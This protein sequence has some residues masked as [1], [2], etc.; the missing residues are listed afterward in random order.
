MAAIYGQLVAILP[1]YI[2]RTFEYVNDNPMFIVYSFCYNPQP[3]IIVIQLTCFLNS[4]NKYSFTNLTIKDLA[5]NIFYMEPKFRL[6]GLYYSLKFIH[7]GS[8]ILYLY[9]HKSGVGV[10]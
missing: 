6:P 9:E 5:T 2:Y 4:C 10:L 3:H 1:I 7:I 8:K